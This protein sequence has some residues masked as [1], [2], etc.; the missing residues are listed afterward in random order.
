V[1]WSAARIDEDTGHEKR[2]GETMKTIAMMG[3]VV[4]LLAVTAVYASE[5]GKEMP[6]MPQPTQEHAWLMQLA[7]NWKADVEATMDPSKPAEKSQGTETV[8]SVGGFWVVADYTGTFMGSPF[9][10]MFTLGYDPATKRYVG[11]WIDSMSSHPWRSEGTVDASGKVLT[12]QGE[13]P[14]PGTPGRMVKFKDTIEL[15]TADHRVFTSM[16][17][18][19]SGKWVPGMTINYTRKP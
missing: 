14:C 7:G 3:L 9:T 1:L 18:D 10:G 19:E 16:M 5:G 13:G 17:E 4:A 2:K 11:M 8:R 12:L 6:P 15:K